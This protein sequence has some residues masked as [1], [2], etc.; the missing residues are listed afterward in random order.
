MSTNKYD[1]PV[2]LGHPAPAPAEPKAIE[3]THSVSALDLM[4]DRDAEFRSA[5]RAAK[6]EQRA[7]TLSD[8]D[9]A[10]FAATVDEFEDVGETTTDYSKLIEWVNRGLLECTRFEVSGA[11][12]VL[13]AANNV[14]KRNE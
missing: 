7:A 2:A 10:L 11:G 6:P 14:D 4:A 12:N 8:E 1:S 9:M 3:G 13:L 5:R